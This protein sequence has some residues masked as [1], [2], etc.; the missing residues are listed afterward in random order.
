[1]ATVSSSGLVSAVAPGTAFVAA[2]SEGVSGTAR[3][4]VLPVPVARVDIT[5]VSNSL[6]LGAQAVLRLVSR[7][8]NGDSLSGRP[9]V[10]QSLDPGVAIVNDS[11]AV[12]AVA[13]GVA[14]ITARVEQVSDT[15]TLTVVQ[16][17]VA[18][19]SLN[20][21]APTLLVRTSLQLVATP[22]DSAG[23]PLAGRSVTWTSMAPSVFSVDQNGLLV[24]LTSG[25]G[26]LV[27]NAEGVEATVQVKV[28]PLPPTIRIDL[29]DL[30]EGVT[31]PSTKFDSLGVRISR[32]S[33]GVPFSSLIIEDASGNDWGLVNGSPITNINGGGGYSPG[34]GG[35][36]ACNWSTTIDFVHP[37]NGQPD[38]VQSVSVVVI[39]LQSPKTF[40]LR[41]YGAVG[42][43]LDVQQF[44]ATSPGLGVL[45]P[46]NI[47]ILTVTAPGI[48]K[49]VID[50]V[51]SD[52]CHSWNVLTANR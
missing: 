37:S 13:L 33:Q 51:E 27:L 39:A 42:G 49:V 32:T 29:G 40:R 44:M 4:D 19:V 35:G 7:A 20:S 36:L 38:P 41:A 3:I 26:T 25:I 21:A 11:G 30:T 46:A 16:V 8:A 47:R 10:W 45:L 9:V 1:V 43:V 24:G 52:A 14:R 31:Y 28:D 50:A 5:A 18:Q 12:T 23:T 2:L 22:R 17:P 6:L 48:L 34:P 15:V